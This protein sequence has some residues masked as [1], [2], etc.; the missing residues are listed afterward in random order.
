M[1]W[2]VWAQND[3]IISTGRMSASM[4]QGPTESLAGETELLPHCQQLD[5]GLCVPSFIDV[6]WIKRMKDE[7]KPRPDD[8]WI[9]T[10]PKS[11][12]TWTQQIVRLI[13]NRGDDHG[14]LLSEVI[15]FVEGVNPKLP[16]YNKSLNLDDMASPRAFKSHFP[17]DQMPCGPPNSTPG[18]Y[19]YVV[20][21]PKDVLVSL[22]IHVSVIPFL[23]EKDWDDYYEQFLQGDVGFG[24]YF[25]NV[26]SWW[27]HKDDDN[28]LFLKYE[29]MKKDLPSAVAAIAK[30]I[31]QDITKELVEE[32]AHRTTFENMK[33][34]NLANY[35]WMN[36]IHRNNLNP[37]VRKGEVGGWKDYFTPEQA[38]K[39]DAVYQGK[40]KAVG[41]DLDFQLEK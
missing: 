21:N 10:Y 25:D 34:D 5:S 18:K 8:I 27:A 12:T 32:I 17:Y 26:L 36:H 38:A 20:R 6:E 37:Y 24:N 15:P 33:K 28:V 9:V 19:I 35:D 39:L 40:L 4:E 30:F 11:G 13:L 31:G 29:D 2:R 16:G 23:V 14:K 7:V 1:V 22:H 41:L 3:Q